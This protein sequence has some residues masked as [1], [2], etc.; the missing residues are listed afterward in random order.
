MATSYATMTRTSPRVSLGRPF[1]FTPAKHHNLKVVSSQILSAPVQAPGFD[2]FIALDKLQAGTSRREYLAG[3]SIF[4]Q[5]DSANAVFYIQSGS[6]RLSVVSMS[7]KEA[8]IAHHP[9]GCFF[10]EAALAGES[11]RVSSASALESSS[12]IRIEKKVMQDLLLREPAFAEQFLAHLLSRI[13]RM[14]A[15]LV[16]HLFNS[17]EKRLARL[18]MMMAN[19]GE[20]TEPTPVIAKISQAGDLVIT[21]GAGDIRAGEP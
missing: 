17:S 5:G 21:I 7:G 15:D 16:D 3:E 11:A 1:P 20:D 19:F 13:I 10:G 2:L 6:V 9:A 12:I 18:L 8:V 14:E 4:S